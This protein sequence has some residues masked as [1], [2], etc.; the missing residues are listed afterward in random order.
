MEQQGKIKQSKTKQGK[1]PLSKQEQGQS[2][3]PLRA[4]RRKQWSLNDK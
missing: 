3:F 2:S 1:F 4:W